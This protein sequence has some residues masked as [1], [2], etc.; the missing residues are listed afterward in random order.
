[1]FL[2]KL[3]CSL[4]VKMNHFSVSVN[5]EWLPFDCHTQLHCTSLSEQKYQEH[6]ISLLL[7]FLLFCCLNSLFL[8]FFCSGAS[9]RGVPVSSFSNLLYSLVP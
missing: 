3:T 5:K 2:L 7:V 4:N 9:S 8:A 6:V 1:V